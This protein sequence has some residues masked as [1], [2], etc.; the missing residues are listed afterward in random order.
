LN[1]IGGFIDTTGSTRATAYEQERSINLFTSMPTWD[2]IVRGPTWV[3]LLTDAVVTTL[4]AEGRDLGDAP[5]SDLTR[6]DC[7]DG[8]AWLC[9]LGP[10]PWHI[11]PNQRISWEYFLAPVLPN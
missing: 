6:I 5:V 11:D 1:A 7:G 9:Q 8:H 10:D 3:T 2:R 4:E